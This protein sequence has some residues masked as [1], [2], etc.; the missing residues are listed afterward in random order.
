MFTETRCKNMSEEE[1]LDAYN[2]LPLS[3]IPNEDQTDEAV[4]YYAQGAGY[5]FFFSPK[6]ATLSFAEGKGHGCHALGL[7]FL[8]ADPHATLTAKK[9]LAGNV[10]YLVG[11]DPSQW[12]RGLPTH[13]ELLY[14]GLW[15][16]IDM[17]VRGERGKLKYEFRLKPGSSV[18]DVRLGYRGAEGLSVGAGGDLLVRTSLGILKDA[19]PV[20]YQLIGGKWV[21]VK[22]RYMLKGDGSNGFAVGAYDPATRSLSTLL[23]G[24]FFLRFSLVVPHRDAR[25]QSSAGR[26]LDT[27]HY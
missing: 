19:A 26:E 18:E 3:F 13:A 15:P 20:S 7:D 6:G 12:Q 22:S 16:G 9:R 11:D 4:R 2:K 25:A 14:G 23:L 8:G 1:A 10:N 24:Q 5:G 27:L 21:P 17:A